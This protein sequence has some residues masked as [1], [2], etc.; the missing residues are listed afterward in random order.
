MNSVCVD[1]CVIA[2]F[3]VASLVVLLLLT[4]GASVRPVALCLSPA[5]TTPGSLP[6]SSPDEIVE[7]VD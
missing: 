2:Q 5:P 7:D 4:L 6:C 3:C 1:G